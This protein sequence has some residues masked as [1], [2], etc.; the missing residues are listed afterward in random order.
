MNGVNDERVCCKNDNKIIIGYNEIIKYKP[1]IRSKLYLV[2]PDS[3]NNKLSNKTS[4]QSLSAT[5]TTSTSSSSYS[6][7]SNDDIIDNNLTIDPQLL[8]TITAQKSFKRSNDIIDNNDNKL[9]Y[10]KLKC[11]N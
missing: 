9:T 8:L 1:K 10:K 4:N 7:I 3:S 6:L 11:S 5:L 2:Y